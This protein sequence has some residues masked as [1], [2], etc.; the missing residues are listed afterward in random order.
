MDKVTYTVWYIVDSCIVLSTD[1]V[2]WPNTHGL[3][4]VR[5]VWDTL[6]AAQGITMKSARP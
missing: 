3:G 1:V 5:H 2:V 4:I 6:N